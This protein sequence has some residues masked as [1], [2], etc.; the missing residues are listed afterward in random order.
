M[1]E[2]DVNRKPRTPPGDSRET[3][4][5]LLD[6]AEKLFAEYGYDGV[7]MR[8]LAEKARVNLGATTYHY[9]S[10]KALYI[11]TFM[12]RFRPANAERLRLL[13][14]AEAASGGKPLPVEKIVDCL[15]RP[16]FLE[17][18]N[19]PHFHALLARNLFVPPAFL[20]PVLHKEIKP[21]MDAFVAALAKSL[22]AVPLDLINLRVM[23]SMGALFPLSAHLGRSR[24]AEKPKL[25]EVILQELVRFVS[26]GL[27]SAPAVPPESR[28]PLPPPPHPP[29]HE[30]NNS[31]D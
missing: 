26:A 18:L 15:L 17:G 31:T 22:P 10:K 30:S 14:E 4:G 3:T 27:R 19:H 16:S 24:V 7:G 5:R 2:L 9:G 20:H 1:Y 23:F 8:A 6:T 25:I 12:R 11:E 13:R 28:P 29:A 21:N